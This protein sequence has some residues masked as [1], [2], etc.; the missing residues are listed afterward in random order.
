MLKLTP[1]VFE[2]LHE[3]WLRCA[4]ANIGYLAIALAVSLSIDFMNKNIYLKMKL[5]FQ[6]LQNE[7]TEE[8]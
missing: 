7:R 1:Q 4:S 2:E 6:A 3:Q 5:Q 8:W